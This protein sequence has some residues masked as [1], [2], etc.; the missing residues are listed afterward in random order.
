MMQVHHVAHLPQSNGG[1][2]LKDDSEIWRHLASADLQFS[3]N[4]DRSTTYIVMAA[5]NKI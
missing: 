4:P 1:N 3:V 5:T 2:G